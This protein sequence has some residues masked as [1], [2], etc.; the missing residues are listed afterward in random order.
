MDHWKNIFR[1]NPQ[2]PNALGVK[3]V[4]STLFEG[5]VSK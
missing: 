5:Q 2:Y 3:N 1:L 4:D